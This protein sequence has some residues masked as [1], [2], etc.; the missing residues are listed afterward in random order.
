LAVGL[1]ERAALDRVDQ[2]LG[3]GHGAPAC[4]SDDLDAPRPGV[5]PDESRH[6][7]I[8]VRLHFARTVLR[9]GRSG[10]DGEVPDP[11]A[12]RRGRGRPPKSEGLVTAQALLD[13]AAEVC[14]EWGF[15]GTTL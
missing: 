8:L 3:H 15:D 5:P 2:G 7:N 6:V 9:R 13:A 10:H 12:A 1:V 11:P 4:S 14:A